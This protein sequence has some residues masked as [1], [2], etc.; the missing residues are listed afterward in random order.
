MHNWGAVFENPYFTWFLG[1]WKAIF[2]VK[3]LFSMQFTP[4]SWK[5]IMESM[6][7]YF[8]CLLHILHATHPL[9]HGK[10]LLV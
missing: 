9:H 7:S 5:A 4:F 1:L 10:L 3:Y 8:F 6:E 2:P